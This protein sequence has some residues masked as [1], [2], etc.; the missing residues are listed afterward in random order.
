MS[1]GIYDHRQPQDEPLGSAASVVKTVPRISGVRYWTVEVELRREGDVRI[2]D[3]R[4]FITEAEL[5]GLSENT[6]LHIRKN[7]IG[8]TVLS[9]KVEDRPK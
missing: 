3:L 1:E 8:E 7:V 2:A 6:E 4:K 5:W 9:V